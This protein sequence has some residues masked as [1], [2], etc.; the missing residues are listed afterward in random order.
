MQK[1]TGSFC[2]AIE[3]FFNY[4]PP[5][6]VVPVEVRNPVEPLGVAPQGSPPADEPHGE[7]L[8]CVRTVLGLRTE[9]L[10]CCSPTFCIFCILW[11][12]ICI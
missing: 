7:G 2:G 12:C 1:M 9:T 6:P 10:N 4:H 8:L 11:V 3:F 5:L